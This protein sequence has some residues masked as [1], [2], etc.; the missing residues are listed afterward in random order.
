MGS[1]RGEVG[2][3]RLRRPW[4]R[5]AWWDS[6]GGR[7]YGGRVDWGCLVNKKVS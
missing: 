5:V 6:E 3:K 7:G 4:S 1:K 2:L